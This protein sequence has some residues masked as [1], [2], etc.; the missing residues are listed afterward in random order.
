MK[1][2]DKLIAIAIGSIL[3][4]GAFMVGVLIDLPGQDKSVVTAQTAEETPNAQAIPPD[5]LEP[6]STPTAEEMEPPPG[7]EVI[8]KVVGVEYIPQAV[9]RQR[10]N[11]PSEAGDRRLYFNDGSYVD[12]PEDV[13]LE[14]TYRVYTCPP[15]PYHCP[16]W[17]LYKLVKGEHTL[18]VDGSGYYWEAIESDNMEEFTFLEN[19]VR[20]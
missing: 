2:N 13:T 5:V 17:P 6:W 4:V 12:L 7:M 1:S 11:F 18:P 8:K 10:S 16:A 20:P 14:T 9:A 3:V 19:I 15:A